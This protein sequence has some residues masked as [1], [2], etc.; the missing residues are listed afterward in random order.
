MLRDVPELRVDLPATAIG[1]DYLGY[2][3]IAEAP[4]GTGIQLS[5]LGLVGVMAAIEEGL[6]INLFGLTF[7]IDPLQFSLKLPFVGRLGA[8]IS[9]LLLGAFLVGGLAIYKRPF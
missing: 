5:V 7:G 9:S 8:G 6:E 3:L 2:R 1:K 4:S